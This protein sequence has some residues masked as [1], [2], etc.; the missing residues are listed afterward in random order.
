[1]LEAIIKITGFGFRYFSF[2]WNIF[3]LLLSLSSFIGIILSTDFHVSGASSVNIIRTL[4]VIMI[5]KLF[6]K[7]KSINIISETFIVTFPALLNVGGL[8]VLFLYIFAVLCM[9]LFATVKFNGNLSDNSNFQNIFTSSLT[10]FRMTTGDNFY[11]IMVSLMQ[12][13]SD[14]FYCIDNPTY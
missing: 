9:N 5:L 6:R 1:M 3:D 8:L 2:G 14:N 12:D 4:R 10:L 7:F 13:N 11:D